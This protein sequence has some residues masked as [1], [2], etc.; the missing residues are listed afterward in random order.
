MEE[1]ETERT[2]KEDNPYK[3]PEWMKILK[4]L[5]EDA[6]KPKPKHSNKYPIKSRPRGLYGILLQRLDELNKSCPDEVIP[7]KVVFEKLCRNF[8]M[9]KKQCWE[10][11]LFLRDMGFIGLIPYHGIKILDNSHS[12]GI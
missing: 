10:I 8:S 2:E 4:K 3:E 9:D 5:M 12:S 6:K 7:F 11:I 1:E